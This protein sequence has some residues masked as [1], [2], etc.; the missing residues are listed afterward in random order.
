MNSIA[1]V[2]GKTINKEVDFYI[3]VSDQIDFVVG[4]GKNY[5]AFKDRLESDLERPIRI[6]LKNHSSS[7]EKLGDTFLLI[8]ETMKEIQE[9]DE[10]RNHENERFTFSLE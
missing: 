2:D 4:F 10:K 8:I 3:Q 9:K 5:H 7:K 1:I 6:I